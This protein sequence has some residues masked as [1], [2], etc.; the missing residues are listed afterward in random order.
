MTRRSVQLLL[1]A[2]ALASAFPATAWS[3]GCGHDHKHPKPKGPVEVAPLLG[4]QSSNT[5]VAPDLFGHV[6]IAETVYPPLG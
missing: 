1:S 5:I 3:H 6:C 4:A 2:A